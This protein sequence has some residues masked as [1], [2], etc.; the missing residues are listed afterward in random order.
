MK[1]TGILTFEPWKI[2]PKVQHLF[3]SKPG[4]WAD[5]VSVSGDWMSPV[6]VHCP[7]ALE[8]EV[9]QLLGQQEIP[10]SIY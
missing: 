1:S 7:E 8:L 9:R 3:E 10:Y 2:W 4:C 5:G 6:T